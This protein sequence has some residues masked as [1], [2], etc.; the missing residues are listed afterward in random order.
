MHEYLQAY[1]LFF[2]ARQIRR[3]LTVIAARPC[4]HVFGLGQGACCHGDCCEAMHACVGMCVWAC[5][6]RML[7][8]IAARQGMFTKVC[9]SVFLM[10]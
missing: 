1:A 10:K 6:R 5:T 2:F 4:M 8:V 7:T 3:I 9:V